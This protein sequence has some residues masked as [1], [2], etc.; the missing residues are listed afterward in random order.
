MEYFLIILLQFLGA[1]FHIMQKIVTIGDAHKEFT[2]QQVFGAF[3][4]EDWD[5]LAVSGLILFLNLVVHFILATYP[6]SIV[7]I[8]NYIL[9][10]FLLSLILGYA[11]QRIVYKYLGSAERFLNKKADE[12]ENR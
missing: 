7:T 12:L 5:T 1:G 6:N 9:Y 11:G 4:K 8:N 2:W 3:L 10:S